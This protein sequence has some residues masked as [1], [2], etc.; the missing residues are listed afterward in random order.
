MRLEE[1]FEEVIKNFPN[2]IHGNLRKMR[3]GR[4]GEVN[5]CL[6]QASLPNGGGRIDLAFV[7]DTEIHVVELKR[8]LVDRDAINQV[9]TYMRAL[10][11]SYPAHRVLGYV[12][13]GRCRDRDS[14]YR[15]LEET[16]I[17][18]RLF[19][20]D[21][22]QPMNLTRCPHCFAG[23]DASEYNC[24]YCSAPCRNLDFA[25]EIAAV[26]GNAMVLD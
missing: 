3:I 26:N 16:S 10:R 22:P 23:F 6:Q 11:M 24:P 19:G 21:M 5:V 1:H 14:L 18:I 2:L 4:L 9:E 25:S 8:D 20:R 12:V 13:G 7:T 15:R 17:S